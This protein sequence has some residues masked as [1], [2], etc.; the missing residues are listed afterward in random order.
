M[1]GL[2]KYGAFMDGLQDLEKLIEKYGI[3][4]WCRCGKKGKNIVI[5]LYK[6]H[7]NTERDKAIIKQLYPTAIITTNIISSVVEKL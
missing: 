1:K 7:I 4:S 2:S 5:D 6:N 3:D